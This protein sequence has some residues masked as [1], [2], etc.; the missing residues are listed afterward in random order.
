MQPNDTAPRKRAPR[1]PPVTIVCEVCGTSFTA[2]QSFVDQG[3]ARFCGQICFQTTR[4]RGERRDCAQCGSEFYAKPDKIR[5][6][7]GIYCGKPCFDEAQRNVPIGD[8]FWPRVDKTDGCWLWT[9]ALNINGYG[10][11]Y[12]HF[13][14]H[15]QAHRLAWEMSS[16]EALTPDEPICHT[17]DV[18]NCVRNDDEGIYEVDGVAYPRRGHLFKGTVLANNHDMTQKGR[19]LS[20]TM[21][22]EDAIREIR[23]TY[24]QGGISQSRLAALFGVSQTM[25]STIVLRK[26]WKHV[27]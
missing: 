23:I 5:R 14:D 8:R 10:T 6:G 7:A 21:L 3:R 12:R 11:I 1:R 13:P 2:W 20:E 22:N 18:R 16:G 4:L 17:C 9:G 19:G 27:V 26:T 15:V 25:I 24:A